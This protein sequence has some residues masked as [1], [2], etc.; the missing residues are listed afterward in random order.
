MRH[1]PC[2]LVMQFY[3]LRINIVT[4]VVGQLDFALY[5]QVEE[6]VYNSQEYLCSLRLICREM[7]FVMSVAKTFY[8]S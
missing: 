4:C 7:C 2:I 1:S 3:D 6:F 8:V 5:A